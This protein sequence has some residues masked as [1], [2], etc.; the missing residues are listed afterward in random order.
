MRRLLS[1]SSHLLTRELYGLLSLPK[2]LS[3]LVS[4]RLLDCSLP[5]AV[6]SLYSL[7][8]YIIIIILYYIRYILLVLYFMVFI[9]YV[10]VLC[11]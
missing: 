5:W 4:Y 7:Y 2:A 6:G 9:F 3:Q 10:Y 11:I 1:S 8:Y